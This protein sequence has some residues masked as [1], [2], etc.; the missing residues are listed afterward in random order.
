MSIPDDPFTPPQPPTRQP[1]S[2]STGRRLEHVEPLHDHD[3][4]PHPGLPGQ[5]TLGS[6]STGHHT[7]AI[8]IAPPA[9]TATAPATGG[10]KTPRRVQWNNES[11]VV[12]L[13]PIPLSP[14]TV[15]RS[16]LTAI[17]A[18]LEQHRNSPSPGRPLSQLSIASS[19]TDGADD[20]DYRLDVDPPNHNPTHTHALEAVGSA[21]SQNRPAEP[22]SL[23]DIL[24]TGI[25]DH[26]HGET[27]IA[28]GETDGL[29]NITSN[30]QA[31]DLSEAK[32]LVR[33]HTGKWGVLRRRVKGAGAVSRAFGTIKEGEVREGGGGLGGSEDAEKVGGGADGGR[34]QDAFAARYPEPREKGR[35]SF[36]GG[37]GDGTGGIGAMNMG[38]GMPQMPGGASVLSSLLALYNQQNMPGSGATSAASSRPSS[39]Y[40][41]SDDEDEKARAGKSADIK[42]GAGG[43]WQP[44]EGNGAGDTSHETPPD[45]IINREHRR[46]SEVLLDDHPIPPPHRSQSASSLTADARAT[47]GFLSALRRARKYTDKIGSQLD[48]ADRPKAARSGAGVWG[49]LIQNTQNISGVATPTAATLA[50]AAARPGYQLNRYTLPTADALEQA[51]SPWRPQ[52]RNGS[53]PGSRPDSMH[54]GT[55]VSNAE[56]PPGRYDPK[57]AHSAVD[58]RKNASSDDMIHMKSSHK[59]ESVRSRSGLKLDS[60]GKLPVAAF[61]SSGQALKSG[62]QAVR[63]AEKWVMSGGRTPLTPPAMGEKGQMDYFARPMT[64]DERR[65]KEWESEKRRRKKQKEARKKQEIF[66]SPFPIGKSVADSQII[67]HVA[68]ILARQQFL[69][70]LARALMMFG[71]PSHRLETQI[72]ATARVLEINAQVVYLPGTMLISFGDDATHTSETKFLKQATGLDLGKLLA[73]HKLYWNVSSPSSSGINE[74]ELTNRSST[75]GSRSSKPARTSMCS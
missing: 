49:A 44:G 18:M 52:S 25:N 47:P 72:Q 36:S 13:E 5:S 24:D 16:N 37:M 6:S 57:K 21:D 39:V 56:S 70:K 3:G 58:L 12:Q 45:V 60:L 10:T 75:I 33:A 48:D 32:N 67:Q 14:Q 34:D 19:A 69:M 73:T 42:K 64:E 31:D 41:S 63:N 17:D 50:P 4:P 22:Q 9:G 55:A 29:P 66:V 61:K 11:H 54:S 27:N 38:N 65:R 40:E 7:P 28:F 46:P 51:A 30:D 23:Q 35:Q 26:I 8:L 68:A 74:N 62:G 2:I 53:R 43:W 1:L 15:D 20:Y 59:A 71:S